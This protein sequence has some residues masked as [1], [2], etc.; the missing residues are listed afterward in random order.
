LE[1]IAAAIDRSRGVWLRRSSGKVADWPHPGM[2]AFLGEDPSRFADRPNADA[3]LIGFATGHPSPEARESVYR[4]VIEPRAAC[5]SARGCIAPAGSSRKNH[6]Q[7]QAVLTYLVH[8]TGYD[9]SSAAR[10][11]VRV[12]CKCDRWFYRYIGFNVPA[13]LYSRCCLY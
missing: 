13:S 4:D 9:F 11:A 1:P 6:R 7:D 5:A 10:D 12:R 3:T 8:K 2:F